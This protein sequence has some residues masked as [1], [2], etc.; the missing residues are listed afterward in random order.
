M[1]ANSPFKVTYYRVVEDEMI[2]YAVTRDD[3]QQEAWQAR[4]VVGIKSI[5]FVEPDAPRD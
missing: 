5:E 2:V 1:S 4:G 3:A